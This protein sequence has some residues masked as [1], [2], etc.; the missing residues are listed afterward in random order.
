M[1]VETSWGGMC[2]RVQGAD[3]TRG[4]FNER[5]II[6]AVDTGFASRAVTRGLSVRRLNEDVIVGTATPGRQSRREATRIFT[7]GRLLMGVMRMCSDCEVGSSTECFV[8]GVRVA[9]SAVVIWKM[10]NQIL[11]LSDKATFNIKSRTSQSS[12]SS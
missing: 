6:A 10:N 8:G 11:S 3:A 12:L 2:L 4:T 1:V 9:S 5:N 7:Y